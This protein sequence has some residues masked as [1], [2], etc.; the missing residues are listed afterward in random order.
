[1]TKSVRLSLE[2]SAL[3]AK[4]SARE[5]LAE[6]TLLRKWVLDALVRARLDHAVADYTA[7]VTNLGEAAA[8]AGVSVARMLAELD[9]RGIDT[10]SSGHFRTSLEHLA[11]LFGGSAELRAALAEQASAHE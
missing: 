11:D 8:Q 9:A 1:M 6:G 3:L 10:V 5:H 2:E 7:G 4:V